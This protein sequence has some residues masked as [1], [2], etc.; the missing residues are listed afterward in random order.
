MKGAIFPIDGFIMSSIHTNAAAMS[1]VH[2]LRDTAATLATTH[3]EVSSGLRIQ[4][5]ADNAAYW[6]IATT[7]RSDRKAISAVADALGL[8]TA[9][10]GVAYEGTDS[11][12]EI[13][14]AF[15]AR[16]VAAAEPGVDK[17]KIQ[18]ELDQLNAQAESVIASSSFNGVNWLRTDAATHLMQTA[19]LSTSLVSSFVRAADGSIE[20]NTTD[21]NLKLTSM[22]NAGGG[23]ILQKEIGGVGDIGG[24][25][26]AGIN[27]VAHQG[28]ENHAF[29]GPATF[30]STD[31]IEFDLTV[32]A[33]T[34]SAGVVFTGL[35]IDKAVIDA[36]LGTTDGKINTASQM[37]AVLQRVFQ[38]NAV[39]ATAYET[40]FSGSSSSNQFE[41]GSL[42]TSGEPG[43]SIDISNVVSD[44]NGVRPAGFALGLE[45]AP[46]NNHDNMYPQASIGFTK[47]F[48][49][50]PTA[51]IYFDVQVGPGTLQTYTIDR[52]TV[53]AALGTSDGTVGNAA[54]LATV[55]EFASAGSGLAVTASGTTLTFSADQA[56][57][58]EAGNRAARVT[59]ENV[60]STPRWTLD[61]DLAE[62]DVTGTD[63]TVGEYIEGIEYMLKGAISSASLL[64]SL[65]MRIELQSNFTSTLME[66]IDKGVGRLVDADMNE[67]SARLKAAQAQEQL[68]IQS[69]QIANTNAANVLSLFR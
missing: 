9:K 28:H 66:S 45:N 65:Q 57:Y 40:L 6:S 10:V 20:L 56:I 19:E 1:A 54:D 32:D 49:V 16:L 27:S 55:I 39:P 14:T 42:E 47:P 17:A 24:F 12:V 46:I 18:K 67:A 25:R 60:R 37:R 26:R 15:K 63:F 34:H 38:D 48:T 44:F 23:G 64:G 8:G 36:A 68:A 3:G 21:L 62:I 13:L 29:T 58:P 11:I 7:M 52:A 61:F 35:R 33:G 53:D 22:L 51:A 5:A 4:T 59:V 41:I 31:Y 43:S 2:I 69:L 30:G 50:S